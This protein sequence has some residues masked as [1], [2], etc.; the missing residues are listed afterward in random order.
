M[1]KRSSKDFVTSNALETIKAKPPQVDNSEFWY[2]SK[3]DF[4]KVPGYLKRTKRQ[5]AEERAKMDAYLAAQEQDEQAQELPQEEKEQLIRMLKLKWQQ[6]NSD[7]L[8]L[9]FDLDTPAKKKRKEL[10]EAQLQQIEKDIRLLER[11]E[12]LIVMAG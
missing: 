6:I 12:K 3:P 8:K 2:T 11:S 10:Y 1:G 5:I 7:F 4:G 9:P